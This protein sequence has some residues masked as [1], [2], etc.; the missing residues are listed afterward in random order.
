M[1]A[2]NQAL[3]AS[4]PK[5]AQSELV[6]FTPG[7]WF[8]L[9][10]LGAFWLSLINHLRLEWSVN[11]QYSY[12][13]IVPVLAL[14][15]LSRRWKS[16]PVAEPCSR[17]TLLVTVAAITAASWLPLRL[18]EK[19]N[20]D[21]RLASWWMATLTIGITVCWLLYSAGFAAT[22]HFLLPVCF[23][24]VAVPWPGQIEPHL[25]RGLM[26]VNTAFAVELSHWCGLPAEQRS[27]VIRIEGQLVGVDEACSGIRSLQ[28]TLMMA[29]FLGELY[30]LTWRRR[31]L[32]MCSAVAFAYFCNVVRTFSLVWLTAKHGLAS[33]EK[34]H[35][36]AGLAALACS[37]AGLW[38]LTVVFC[39]GRVRGEK[40]AGRL[41]CEGG[42]FRRV[43]GRLAIALGAWFLTVEATAE[44][45]YVLH[46]FGTKGNAAWSVRWPTGKRDYR[47]V[48]IPDTS[49]AI[50][51]YT[52]GRNA[53][54]SGESDTAWQMFFFRW[55]PGRTAS[56]L[57]R[58][59]RPEICLP[60]TGRQLF[61]EQQ[62]YVFE[63]RGLPIPFRTYL[64][65]DS[66]RPLWVFFCAWEDVGENKASAEQPG[67]LLVS[68]RLE[69]VR[70]GRRNRGQQVLEVAVWGCTS[71]GEAETALQ[72]LLG[73]TIQVSS[74]SH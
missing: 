9:V 31:C 5:P 42:G 22:K 72:R 12:G 1:E 73:E 65:N 7:I 14:Y 43:P 36:S 71:G 67:A 51:K 62:L 70:Q 23:I 29:L 66:G 52:E 40:A 4:L 28:T 46:E 16:Q 60:A 8:P 47:D 27:N 11:A 3:S 26:R 45:W 64:F 39:R 58:T 24:L 33:M 13:F 38:V 20:P 57:A 10:V 6:R 55:A 48:P 44:G 54:W 37:L 50:L 19:A 61:S 68:E 21:W 34:W 17:P 63:A 41:A 69:A 30:R 74:V 59:H 15:L 25:V 2:T 49:R 53:A 56:V 32:L 18:I 35:D